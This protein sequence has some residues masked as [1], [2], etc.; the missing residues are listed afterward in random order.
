[1][2]TQSS[3]PRDG[4]IVAHGFGLKVYVDR[5][6]L[7]VHDG[8][9][10]ERQTRR[11]NR[12]TSKLKRVVVIGH[13]GFVTLEAL[14]WIRDIGAAF[15]QI[16][17]D[18]QLVVTSAAAGND[19]APLR[20]S[21]AVAADGPAGVVITRY[22][23]RAKI[24]GHTAVLRELRNAEASR[25]DLE[26]ALRE[27]DDAE[28][29]S[30]LL[31][32]EAQAAASYWRAW[33]SLPLPFGRQDTN[34]APEHWRRFGQRA[35]L[36]TSGP[37]LASNPANAILNYLYAL[38]EAE[39]TIACHRLGLD[40]G[41]GIFHAD[42]RN[43]DSLA[44]DIMEAARPVVDAYV[45]ALLT[46]RTLARSDF[47]ENRQGACRLAPRIAA[48]LA[49]TVVSWKHHVAPIAEQVAHTLATTPTVRSR[50][51]RR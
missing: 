7:V 41:I 43:R 17:R 32:I 24:E 36:L 6:H 28:D 30:S 11:Y 3:A 18:G 39:T 9:C 21:Q 33:T 8:V 34:G 46:Q 5:G 29:I 49:E 38:L 45:L 16:D 37:R 42:R 50:S 20:R 23:L 47:V 27:V 14:R 13:N 51:Q 31:G 44:L 10:D 19:L 22:L 48:R 1:M 15:V 2:Q 25:A 40:P 35:S 26:H 4:I 12:A